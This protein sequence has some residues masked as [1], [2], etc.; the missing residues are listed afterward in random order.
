MISLEDFLLKYY[1]RYAVW[2]GY[3]NHCFVRGRFFKD[4]NDVVIR[5]EPFENDIE[6]VKFIDEYKLDEIY[7]D[8][9]YIYL[10]DSYHSDDINISINDSVNCVFITIKQCILSKGVS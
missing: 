5:N 10:D 7:I 6:V 1:D 3:E 9:S 4:Y 2:I 8:D